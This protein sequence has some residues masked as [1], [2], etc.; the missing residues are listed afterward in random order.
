MSKKHIVLPTVRVLD[1]WTKEIS[2]YEFTF[3]IKMTS[4]GGSP[5]WYPVTMWKKENTRLSV[6]G[7]FED[8]P[9]RNQVEEYFSKDVENYIE[10]WLK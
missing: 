8:C 1:T 10:L 7:K 5:T 3:Q 9:N 2:G 4:G 6:G